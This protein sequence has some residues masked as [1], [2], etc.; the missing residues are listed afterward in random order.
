MD[1]Y[2]KAKRCTIPVAP[3]FRSV[4]LLFQTTHKQENSQGTV[5]CSLVR[6]QSG[7][8]SVSDPTR[9]GGGGSSVGSTLSLFLSGLMMALF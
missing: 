1:L 6:C 5:F 4:L 8:Q 2:N 7:L 9:V 3:P